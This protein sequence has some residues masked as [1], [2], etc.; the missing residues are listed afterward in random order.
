MNKIRFQSL[1][2]TL[3]LPGINCMIPFPPKQTP[4]ETMT[5]ACLHTWQSWLETELLPTAVN[6]LVQSN[7]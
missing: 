5:T 4:A 6:S 2:F 3:T 1:P 7:E